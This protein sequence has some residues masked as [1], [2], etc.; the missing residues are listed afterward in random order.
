MLAALARL[1]PADREVLTLSAWYDLPADEAARAL[2]CSSS[3]YRV[4]L[5]RARR[6]LAELLTRPASAGVIAFVAGEVPDVR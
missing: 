1:S 3:A 6:R 2:Q 5:F 4:R